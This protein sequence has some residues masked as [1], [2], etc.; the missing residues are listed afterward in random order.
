MPIA[1][2]RNKSSIDVIGGWPAVLS[3]VVLMGAATATRTGKF[4]G[5]NG[6]GD[7]STG[8]GTGWVYGGGGGEG[9]GA[10]D[11]GDGGDGEGRGGGGGGGGES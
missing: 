2:I 9:I 5:A 7:R 4:G 6:A 3:A 8:A 1:T 10:G 11:D